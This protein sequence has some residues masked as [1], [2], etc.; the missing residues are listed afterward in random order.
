MMQ[1]PSIL[2]RSDDEDDVLEIGANDNSR[3]FRIPDNGI[4]QM[5]QMPR[6]FSTP[7][8]MT[9]QQGFGG[10]DPLINM[11]KVS[12][13]VVSRSSGQDSRDGTDYSESEADDTESYVSDNASPYNTP[14]Q[15]RMNTNM[16]RNGGAYADPMAARMVSE[17]GRMEAEMNE[18]RE[19]L[20]QLERLESKGYRLPRKFSVQSDLEEMRA[21]YHRILRE[22]EVD[23]SVR[24]QRK[25]MMALV[26]GIE[27]L[28]TRFDPFEVKLD[29]WS[30]QVHESIN[31]YDDIFEELH[32]KYKGA[33]KKM[34]PE[35]R[36][37]MSLSG[38]A[39][40]FHLT[41]SMFKK[42]PLPGVEEV[43]RANP[44]LMKQFQQAS[45]NQLGKNMFGGGS[46]Q[47]Q[48]QESQGGMSGLFGMMSNLMGSGN[49]K[50]PP[51]PNM[52]TKR[53]SPSQSRGN[54]ADIENIIRDI[55]DDIEDVSTGYNMNQNRIET[56][57]LDDDDEIASIL[58]SVTSDVMNSKKQASNKKQAGGGGRRTLNL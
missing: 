28:N 31:D 17:R 22:K 12:S 14:V 46:P 8:A 19:I 18:K 29:G 30:E 9:N 26:T 38:S 27:F 49:P 6:P 43:L 52:T 15:P 23:A 55:H 51:P 56:I 25:M 5:P 39:F 20:Y 24:F 34:A 48:Q 41:N 45:V 33:G 54:D 32:D 44:D 7:S 40:M 35:L 42:S 3:P 11:R 13:D 21:E 16:N 53:P 2:L 36:L 47:Q 57:S 4:Q 10:V 1:G 58:E 37:M 50:M